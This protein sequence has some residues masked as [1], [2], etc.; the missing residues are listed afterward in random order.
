[1]A[2]LRSYRVP[3][4]EDSLQQFS[5]LD[6]RGTVSDTRECH[7]DLRPE[8]VRGCHVSGLLPEGPRLLQEPF[9]PS[10]RGGPELSCLHALLVV[11]LCSGGDPML[12]HVLWRLT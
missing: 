12:P 1:M 4:N 11:A 8:G 3:E 5:G 10:A 2:G 6:P 9:R 7:L